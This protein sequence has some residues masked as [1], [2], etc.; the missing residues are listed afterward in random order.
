MLHHRV[1]SSVLSFV[2]CSSFGIVIVIVI[3]IV[4]VIVI[5]D[6]EE[7]K[8]KHVA[9]VATEQ[10]PRHH[11]LSAPRVLQQLGHGT[12]LRRTRTPRGVPGKGKL[13][14]SAPERGQTAGLEAS[15][16]R[17]VVSPALALAPRAEV[18]ARAPGAKH[19]A[20]AVTDA[21]CSVMTDGDDC[22]LCVVCCVLCDRGDPKRARLCHF[23]NHQT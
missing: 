14:E 16:R 7:G 2:F 13:V 3:L 23:Q 6:P 20:R 12:E 15:T 19:C 8:G 10:Q 17:R 9:I 11:G 18:Q 4:I 1:L 21:A 22:V 5:V